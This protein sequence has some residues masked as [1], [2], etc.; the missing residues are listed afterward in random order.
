[1]SNSTVYEGMTGD[2]S[3][4]VKVYSH[5]EAPFQTKS[6]IVEYTAPWTG[7]Q[8]IAIITEQDLGQP[9]THLAAFDWAIAQLK[10]DFPVSGLF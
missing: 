4:N 1:M 6:A 2:V 10:I 3:I 9:V 8:P 7:T 5:G